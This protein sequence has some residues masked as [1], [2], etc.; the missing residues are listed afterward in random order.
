MN[1]RI[2][3][4]SNKT[5]MTDILTTYLHSVRKKKYEMRTDN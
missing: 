5:P 3:Q 2:G 4:N 1:K